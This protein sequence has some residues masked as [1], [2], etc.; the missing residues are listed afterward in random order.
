LKNFLVHE[1]RSY[2]HGSQE[3]LVNGLYVGNFN[4]GIPAFVGRGVYDDLRV[5]GRIQV[6]EPSGLY[7][8]SATRVHY[9]TKGAEYLIKNPN[10]NYSWVSSSNGDY[11]DDAVSPGYTPGRE[12]H[13]VGR[14]KINDRTFYGKM[15]INV[16]MYYENANNAE[17][18]TSTYEVLTC[19]PK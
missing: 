1:W 10:Y 11:V 19:V 13:F 9:I 18:H 4:Q 5:T 16:G 12:T 3:P 14:I 17:V 15:L 8:P 2:E 7:H 6:S